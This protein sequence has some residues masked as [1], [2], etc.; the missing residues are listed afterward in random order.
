MPDITWQLRKVH[1]LEGRPAE[2]GHPVSKRLIYLDAQI[3]TPSISTIYDRKGDIWKAFTIGKAHPDFHLPVN[4]G[5]GIPLD[6][7][8]SMVDLQANHCTMIRFRGEIDPAKNP[9]TLFQV[10]NLR[11][12]D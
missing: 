9:A 8:G 11:G 1:V 4:K 3:M 10:Q 6:D 12:G 2:A 7:S 5:S